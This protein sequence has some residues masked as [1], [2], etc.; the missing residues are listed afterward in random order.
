MIMSQFSEI[1]RMPEMKAK[2]FLILF[3]LAVLFTSPYLSEQT[4][5][6]ESTFTPA[7]AADKMA[8][9]TQACPQIALL[10]GL[11]QPLICVT[12]FPKATFDVFIPDPA[13]SGIQAGTIWNL[14]WG[15]G[16]INAPYVSASANDVPP[17]AWRQHTYSSVSD[18]NYIVSNG[19]RNPCG[20][21]RGVQ[22]VAVVHG[23]DIPADGDGV[24]LLVDN[25][26]GSATIEVCEGVQSIITIRD[27]SIWNCQ[28]P[29]VPGG[30]LAVP[31]IDPRNIEWLYGRDPAGAITNTITGTVNIAV[32]GAAPRASGRFAPVPNA[33]GSLSQAITIPATCVAGQYFR[34]YLKNWN[35][36]NWLNAE[37]VN[38][39]VDITVVAA[40][41]AP[42]F[43]TTT[44][45]F[46]SVPSS[47]T[48]TGT[49]GTIRWYGNASLTTLLYTGA[50]YTHGKTAVG[51]YTYYVT[52]TR[53]GC[54]G[55]TATVVL[56]IN[57]IPNRPVISRNNPDFC[58]NGTSSIT[59]T[60]SFTSPPSIS[61]YQWYKGGTA[62]AGA[63]G[64][65]ITLNTV[66]QSGRYS[67]DFWCCPDLLSKSDFY[68]CDSR[69]I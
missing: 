44:F 15:D 49:G 23:R 17:L 2:R 48:A 62:I 36:C 46:G 13:N 35:K 20:E 54:V 32:L 43:G 65:T 4:R 52:E 68:V 57:P 39:Y 11:L 18:C 55:P 56:T 16:N 30:L 41:P 28:N 12:K 7:G 3:S 19:I 50:S 29:V 27:N 61:S 63:T 58:F 51:S 67:T 42:T 59:L 47:I 1:K 10:T 64:S 8:T 25:A 45:C 31:N 21:T 5:A 53:A 60:A 40:P 9:G 66:A 6:S 69:H 24:L 22:Y 38:T 14:D 33:P 26:T 34:V 37:F